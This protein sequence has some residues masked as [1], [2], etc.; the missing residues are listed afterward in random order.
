MRIASALA[1]FHKIRPAILLYQR[2]YV[3]DCY[4]WPSR[5]DTSSALPFY[6]Y[7]ISTLPSTLSIIR[8]P[9]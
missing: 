2:F 4:F 5:I 7:S 3:L 9:L 1:S 6:V 8:C